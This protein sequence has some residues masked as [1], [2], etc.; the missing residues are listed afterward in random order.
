VQH[1]ERLYL[2]A[3]MAHHPQGE[4]YLAR[5]AAAADDL[6][7]GPESARPFDHELIL[8]DA[9]TG[10][11]HA[12]AGAPLVLRCAPG[13]RTVYESPVLTPATRFNEAVISW[14]VATPPGSGFGVE[15]RVGRTADD[16]W[17][18]WLYVGDWGAPPP[19]EQCTSFDGGQIDTDYFRSAER[20][21]RIQYRIRAAAEA[22]SELHVERVA[23][24]VSDTTGIPPSIWQA[25]TRLELSAP[26][27]AWQ[28]RLPVPF[29][30]Q[31][32]TDPTMAGQICSPTSLA[33]VLEYRGVERPT[34]EV[35]RTAFDPTHE[36][37]GNWPRNIQ[38]AYA[39][40]V[41]GYLDHFADWADVERC[42]AADQPLIISI[43]FRRGE[44]QGAE[45][46]STGGHLI[47][48]TG[49]E[50]DDRV[51][52]NDPAFRDPA[53]GQR[54]YTRAELERVWLRE[55]GGLAYI[56]LPCEP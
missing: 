8:H 31:A 29:R 38:A 55:R 26:P 34:A 16:F 9:A 7:C 54:T 3:G 53:K 45:Y 17:S 28:R 11:P 32:T 33:M 40:G 30:T 5:M 56:L 27:S 39:L 37:F 21:D 6:L 2:L 4:E 22:A 36:I 50:G 25:D 41:P 42:I 44:L 20:Y 51:A 12:T 49:F 10:F 43:R 52:V 18:P 23:V 47:V 19:G 13:D 1:G 46:N 14:N 35:A 15:V 48:L 24:C